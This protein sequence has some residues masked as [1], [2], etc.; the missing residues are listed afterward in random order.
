MRVG[1]FQPVSSYSLIPAVLLFPVA[2]VVEVSGGGVGLVAEEIPF[3]VCYVD[4]LCDKSRRRAAD[5]RRVRINDVDRK[6][7]RAVGYHFCRG[8]VIAMKLGGGIR[9]FAT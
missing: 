5:G 6:Q 7:G 8:A 1:S 3:A 2:G 4:D 9:Q